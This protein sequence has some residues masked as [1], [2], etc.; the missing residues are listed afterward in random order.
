[1]K[2]NSFFGLAGMVS[3]ALTFAF[4]LAVGMA[5]VGCDNS[6]N[7]DADI[8]EGTWIG[9]GERQGSTM[10]AANGSYTETSNGTEIIK[11][12]YSVA[13]NTVTMTMV[14]LNTI[15]FG[16]ADKWFKWADLDASY[17]AM[18]LNSDTFQ[19]TIQGDSIVDDE[20]AAGFNRQK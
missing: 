8:F 13:G 14:Q 16:G 11:G 18:L 5:F 4:V 19:V 20:G 1:M 10:V 2:K 6:T 9:T 12:T 3:L 17:K 7:G 15:A